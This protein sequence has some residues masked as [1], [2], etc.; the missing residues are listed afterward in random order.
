MITT[1]CN[2]FRIVILPSLK[3]F[4][5][6]QPVHHTISH[7]IHTT[8]LPLTLTQLEVAARHEFEHMLSLQL[9]GITIARGTREDPR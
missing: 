2:I 3:S 6:N 5:P 4:V 8:G 9:L 7:H 1:E